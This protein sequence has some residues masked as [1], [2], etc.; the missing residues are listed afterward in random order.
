MTNSPCSLWLSI[1]WCSHHWE[2][3]SLG[4]CL[5]ELVCSHQ[6]LWKWWNLTWFY[7]WPTHHVGTELAWVL[8]FGEDY[9]DLFGSSGL[10]VQA[11]EISQVKLYWI[12]FICATFKAFCAPLG[13]EKSS[14]DAFSCLVG[15]N[16]HRHR[17]S[18]LHYELL[19]FKLVN[20][21]LFCNSCWSI[22]RSG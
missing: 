11:D 2:L 20:F 7:A 10:I 22:F 16:S 5:K 18:C 13:R 19:Q 12:I 6:I 14:K 15:C 4:S 17:S 8:W 3:Q 9:F 21:L 1:R